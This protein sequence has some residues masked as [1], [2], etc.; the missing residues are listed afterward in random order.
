MTPL[1]V[2]PILAVINIALL[3][4]LVIVVIVIVTTIVRKL[5]EARE[6]AERK[7][8][9]S[10]RPQTPPPPRRE[11]QFRNE[12]EAFLDEV[13]K[14]RANFD[15]SQRAGAERNADAVTPLRARPLPRP[16]PP[17]PSQPPLATRAAELPSRAKSDMPKSAPPLVAPLAGP[18]RP[19]AELA[20]RKAP[21]SANMGG[22][23]RA[24]LAQYL[25][26]GRMSQTV[27]SDL[28]NAVERS[29]VQHLGETVTR[30]A[31][32]PKQ[33]AST[34][35]ATPPLAVLLRDPAGARTAIVM[36]EILGPPKGLRRK[37]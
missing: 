4:V 36:N 5:N 13:G 24:H 16:E 12:I 34:Q 33:A 18:A 1:S 2:P 31:D 3:K 14:R 21:V 10:A 35:S 17:K 30:G 27:R 6:V 26:P 25:D 8:A 28:G 11:N 23:V 20:A 19:G 37:H 15:A 9:Q 22:Q 32:D 29:L 7:K